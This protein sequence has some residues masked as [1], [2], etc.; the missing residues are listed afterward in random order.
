M[1]AI[2]VV[3]V[4]AHIDA[5]LEEAASRRA[6]PSTPSLRTRIADLIGTFGGAVTAPAVS[7]TD[8]TT[9]A[10]VHPSRG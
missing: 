6:A 5:L 7:R 3:A 2:A 4:T 9:I 1:Y 10:S 8:T